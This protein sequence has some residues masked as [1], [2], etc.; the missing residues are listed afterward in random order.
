MSAHRASYRHLHKRQDE[1]AAPTGNGVDGATTID[2]AAALDAATLAIDS[3]AAPGL[4]TSAPP[5][6]TSGVPVI[7][8]SKAA[9]TPEESQGPDLS[10]QGAVTSAGKNSIPMSTVVGACLGALAGCIIIILVGL[11]VYRRTAPKRR[12]RQPKSMVAAYRNNQGDVARRRSRLEN[13]DKLGEGDDKWEPKFATPQVTPTTAE[14][15]PMEKLTMFKSPSIRTAY[16][17][18][19]E[20]HPTF[21]LSPHPF[22][23]YHPGLAQDMATGKGDSPNEPVATTRQFLGRVDVGPTISWD[24][25]GTFFSASSVP[26]SG[27]A[28]TPHVTSSEPHVWQS[29]EVVEFED[30]DDAHSNNPFNHDLERAQGT[31]NNNPFFSAQASSPISKPRSPAVPEIIPPTTTVDKGKARDL[32][33]SSADP[34]GDENR[35][36]A[37]PADAAS[38]SG[39]SATSNDHALQ[40]LLAALDLPEEERLRVT[41]MQP[42]LLS[43]ASA[44]TEEDV[45]KAF[46]LPPGPYEKP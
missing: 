35:L 42:S 22:A 23:A 5:L 45:T 33:G 2:T 46:P 41:S 17:R 44:Y 6:V 12:A 18:R 19:S 11:F 16:T 43:N 24:S 15:G 1:P 8:T 21:D 4:T 25:Q 30:V 28:S 37:P 10:T 7:T 9:P 34:F 31:N 39:A 20:E 29:A 3:N 40:S 36:A 13:W 26:A 32:T 38:M 27:L 14:I